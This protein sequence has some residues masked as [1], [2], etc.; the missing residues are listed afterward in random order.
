MLFLQF[1]SETDYVNGD[2]YWE[3]DVGFVSSQRLFCITRF[4]KFREPGKKTVIFN[5]LHANITNRASAVIA[6][7]INESMRV[8][9]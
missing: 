3:E 8:S 9:F 1:K 2:F 4:I 6:R 5:K 7:R